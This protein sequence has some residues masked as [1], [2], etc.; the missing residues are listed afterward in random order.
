MLGTWSKERFCGIKDYAKRSQTIERLHELRP[1]SLA[2]SSEKNASS[3]ERAPTP[4]SP[5][6]SLTAEEKPRV[7]KKP[8]AADKQTDNDQ[9]GSES[10]HT[11]VLL[12]MTPHPVMRV[13]DCQGK[14]TPHPVRRLFHSQSKSTS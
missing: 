5:V 9:E 14:R 7:P 6:P 3:D 12:T 10:T 13:L 8:S 11:R 4:A 2:S 1:D